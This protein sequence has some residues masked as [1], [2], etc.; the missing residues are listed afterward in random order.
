VTR[1][2]HG[3]GTARS[4]CGY[5]CLHLYC[6]LQE[7]FNSVDATADFVD[8]T[9]AHKIRVATSKLVDTARACYDATPKLHGKDITWTDFKKCF[10]EL[11][12]DSNPFNLKL[13]DTAV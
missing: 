2:T 9:D 13:V 10:L 1:P 3:R 8:W 4:R 5:V 6:G 12:K 11:F 7:L